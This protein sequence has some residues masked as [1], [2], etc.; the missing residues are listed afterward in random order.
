MFKKTLRLIS[1]S[2]F[3][4][5]AESETFSDHLRIHQLLDLRRLNWDIAHQI[6]IA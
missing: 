3:I 6:E 1:E 5:F 2:F 4:A